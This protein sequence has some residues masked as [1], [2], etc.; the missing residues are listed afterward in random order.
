MITVLLGF[1]LIPLVL[2]GVLGIFTTI[3]EIEERSLNVLNSMLRN[4][5]S[6]VELFLEE[7]LRLLQVCAESHSALELSSDAMLERMLKEMRRDKG[8]IVDIGL[9]DETG[10]HTA[11]VG[12][13]ALRDKDYSSEQWFRE[14]MVKGRYISDVFL[15]FR[16]FPHVSVAVRKQEDGKNFVLRVSI[17][18]DFLTSLVREGAVESNADVFI[19][20][21]D[22]V[23]QTAYSPEQKL[24]E[25]A[26]VG[27]IPVHS[28]VRIVEMR[29]G[30]KKFYLGSVWLLGDKWVLVA[31][32][33]VPGVA[34]ILLAYPELP[35]TFGVALVVV[36]ILALY[37]ARL[38]L[39]QVRALER[40][41]AELLEAVS[42]SQKIAAIGR[43]AAGIAHEINNPLAIIQAQVGVLMDTL[44]DHPEV[45]FADDFKAR[46]KKIEAQIARAS[47]I[48]HRLLGFSRRV[49]PQVEPVDLAE[50]LDETLGFVEKEIETSNIKI[51]KAYEKDLPLV[52]TSLA[53]VQQV[54][55]NLI[56]N[57]IDA[58]GGSGGV[59]RVAVQKSLDGVEVIIED[60]GKGIP[61]SDLPKIFEPFWT[62]KTGNKEHTGLGLAIC[63]DIMRS[64]GGTIRVESEEGKGT[65]FTLWF[66]LES[67]MV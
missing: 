30:A 50:A 26:W 21:K 51:E 58:L 59:I 7:K 35:I 18:S 62:T 56:N 11:Y 64:V 23:Y 28:D 16:K 1:G 55:L 13:Y 63:A 60:N 45:P 12:P 14:T 27:A 46:I 25:K 3:R 47:T 53:R 24:M 61:K 66:P 42:H 31:K 20:N 33:E 54:F 10:R 34:D 41:H 40:R 6:T 37:V 5:A 48:T 2:V 8:G 4:R 19:L 43:L 67:P 39:R 44:Q 22:G 15:G 65:R 29:K 17:D 49:G 9:I 52:R 57:A 38:R 36:P 32:Q